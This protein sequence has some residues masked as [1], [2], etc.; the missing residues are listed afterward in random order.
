L[1]TNPANSINFAFLAEHDPLFL[2]LATSAELA[3]THDPN[4]TLIKLRQLGEAMAQHL[5]TESGVEFDEQT[6]QADLL[7]QLGRELNLDYTVRSLFKTLRIEG[8]KAT[9]QFKTDPQTALDG[10]KVAHQL[11]MW[12]HRSFSPDASKFDAQPFISPSLITDRVQ[13]DQQETLL[14]RQRQ[15]YERKIQQLQQQ[16]SQQDDATKN[17][18]KQQVSQKTASASQYVVL[19]EAQTRLL[20]DVQLQE[21][22]WE[23]DSVLLDYRKGALPEKGKTKRLPNGQLNLTVKMVVPIMYCL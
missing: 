15:D 8:N 20:I 19:D 9:H 11:A 10:L 4:T 1:N 21:A 3:F 23:A 14:E 16:L 7:Y 2:Q 6:T 22:G 13:Q 18:H 5:A 12:F 17:E